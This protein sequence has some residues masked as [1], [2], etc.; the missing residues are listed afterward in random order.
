[1]ADQSLTMYLKAEDRASSKVRSIGQQINAEMETM[2]RAAFAASHSGRELEERDLD[3][4]FTRV[5]AKYQAVA[6]N[7]RKAES[8]I[9]EKQFAAWQG[10]ETAKSLK[11][12]PAKLE[13]DLAANLQLQA[14]NALLLTEIAKTETAARMQMAQKAAQQEVAI[15]K[16][17]QEALAKD[18]QNIQRI[19]FDATHTARERDLRDAGEYFSK[20]LDKHRGN[21]DM[22][23]QIATAKTARVAEIERRYAAGEE[24]GGRAGG[25][26]LGG[27]T[28]VIGALAAVHAAAGLVAGMMAKI[29]A[30]GDLAIATASGSAEAIT[31]AQLKMLDAQG[32]ML[33][34]IPLIGSAIKAMTDSWGDRAGIEKALANIQQIE[35]RITQLH[36]YRLKLAEELAIAE[37]TGR[38]ETPGQIAAIQLGFRPEERKTRIAEAW[39]VQ[40]SA[41]Q[42]AADAELKV[43]Q[44]R[45]KFAD[46]EAIR[47]QA[48]ME[49]GGAIPP[50]RKLRERL[51]AAEAIHAEL[52][53][54]QEKARADY[55]AIARDEKRLA[56]SQQQTVEGIRQLEV[57]KRRGD[58][59][60]FFGE[61]EDARIADEEALEKTVAAA[62]AKYEE[63]VREEWAELERVKKIKQEIADQEMTFRE[64]I[65]RAAGKTEEAEELAITRKYDALRRDFRGDLS[66]L[67]AAERAEMLAI[68]K[69]AGALEGLEGLQVR[70]ERF[71]RPA[72]DPAVEQLAV[73]KEMRDWLAKIAQKEGV[74]L[75]R[76]DSFGGL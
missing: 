74:L 19:T 17:A 23:V 66:L 45:Q 1:M 26:R 34:A 14:R 15:Q 8:S 10:G 54:K 61:Q 29:R 51:T 24:A 69:P 67:N 2:Q 53:A 63:S 75:A 64:T 65:L 72:Q 35:G 7:L 40:Q 31:R 60:R 12:D 62:R 20:L 11:L 36:A 21:K 41:A 32:Q 16:S 37:A 13:T 30:E 38:G 76:L 50:S 27:F 73:L 47:R 3:G 42:A 44:A 46:A 22:E 55:E 6:E 68:K 4:H 28:R 58:L 33:T 57:I 49:T 25:F 56:L 39:A 43:Q 52:K 71:I 5:K 18:L 70:A 48:E 59:E 9:L